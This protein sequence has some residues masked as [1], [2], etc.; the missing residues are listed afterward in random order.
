VDLD[1]HTDMF[2]HEPRLCIRVNVLSVV[3]QALPCKYQ[4]CFLFCSA[5]RVISLFHGLVL[6]LL[7]LCLES[8]LS[9]QDTFSYVCDELT[10]KSQR[11]NFTPLTK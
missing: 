11:R 2:R 1:S 6:V 5:K 8:V 7:K 9:H 4:K 3:S 10:F